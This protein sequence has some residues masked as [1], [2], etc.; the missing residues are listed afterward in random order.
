MLTR[1]VY[2]NWIAAICTILLIPIYVEAATA[3]ATSAPTAPPQQTQQD[4]VVTTD[5]PDARYNLGDTVIFTARLVNLPDQELRYTIQENHHKEVEKGRLA[6]KD[7]VA[8]VTATFQTPGFLFLRINPPHEL[9]NENRR[10]A[11]RAGAVCAP[12]KLLPS[13]PVPEDFNAFW[14][15]KKAIMNDIPFNAQLTLLENQSNDKIEVYSMTLDSYNGTKAH[16]FLAKPKGNTACPAIMFTHGA[17]VRSFS[18]QRVQTWAGYGAIAIEVS[19]HDIP[20]DQPKEFYTELAEGKLKGYSRFGCDDRETSYFLRMFLSCYQAA[21]LVTSLPEW[22]GQRFVVYGSS[23]GGGQALATAYLC[24]KVS[25]FFA[26][27]SA[28]CDHA[29]REAGRPAGWPRWVSYQNNGMADARQLEASRYFDGVNFARFIKAKA[30]MSCGFIDTTCPPSSVYAAFN[31]L[32]GEKQ[33]VEMPTAAHETPP[34]ITET[35]TAFAKR[36][37]GLTE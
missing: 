19:A 22:D 31:M 30:L 7:G 11:G 26:N 21:R 9:V 27:V 17:G 13:L 2:R 18:A 12:D 28:L 24:D 5:R 36:Q 34:M 29:G 32:T 10:R 3:V 25:A 1:E 20:N 35:A 23:Q 33:M 4:L 15:G 6:F 14:D 16:G 8:T 37:L